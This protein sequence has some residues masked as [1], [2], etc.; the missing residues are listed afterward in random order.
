[1]SYTPTQWQ[2]GDVITSEKLNKLENGVASSN[3]VTFVQLVEQIDKL[4]L[5]MP[6]SELYQALQNG[7]VVVYQTV[8]S[9]T[10]LHYV[11]M[12]FYNT[13]DPQNVYM[14]CLDYGQDA[15]FFVAT[16]GDEYPHDIDQPK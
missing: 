11:T 16:T 6:A 7:L 8:N 10:C 1:M 12:Y 13:G 3:G 15:Q 2:A 4:E 5:M 14:F 9:S